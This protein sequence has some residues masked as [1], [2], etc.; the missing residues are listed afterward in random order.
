MQRK[1]WEDAKIS[2][3]SFTDLFEAYMECRS[4]KRNTTNALQF[5]IDYEANLMRLLNEINTGQYYPGRS[6]AFV[7]DKP[8][9]R[10]IFAADL[11]R[12]IKF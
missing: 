3:I 7:I 12:W 8:V 4:N 5:E 9:K 11:P 6:I 10:E 1:L 2:G